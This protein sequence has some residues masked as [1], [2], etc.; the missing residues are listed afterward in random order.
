MSAASFSSLPEGLSFEIGELIMLRNW[1]ENNCL[2]LR[3]DL[4]HAEGAREYEEFATLS[5]ISRERPLATLW[6]TR[7]AVMTTPA[8]GTTRRF[9]S[10]AHALAALHIRNGSIE[11]REQRI[12][13]HR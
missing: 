3:L 9:V 6:R 5:S 1:A 13:G 7:H 10:M 12:A 4:D 11:M 8:G 2:H